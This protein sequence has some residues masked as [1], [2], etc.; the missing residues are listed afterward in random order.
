MISE[1]KVLVVDL[2]GT[3]CPI[4]G[5][6]ENYQDLSPEPAL[7]SRIRQLADEGWR[8]V[9]H[10]SRGMRTHRGNEGEIYANVLPVV[11]DWLR[12]H[13][14]PH[15]E[16]RMGKPWPGHDGF[17]IDDRAVRPREF[18]ENDLA[19]LGELCARDRVAGAE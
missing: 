3:L 18:L 12:R 7:V 14:I 4:K 1:T 17:Y 5:K 13:D 11:V 6:G 9:I 16:V 2:D 15:H 10:S 19:G 8:I